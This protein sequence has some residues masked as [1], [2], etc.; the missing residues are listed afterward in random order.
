MNEMGLNSKATPI[1]MVG[2]YQAALT[3]GPKLPRLTKGT[4][5]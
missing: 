1:V 4:E 3:L 2:G 5:V